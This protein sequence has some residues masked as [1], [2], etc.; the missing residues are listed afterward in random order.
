MPAAASKTEAGEARLSAQAIIDAAPTPLLVLDSNLNVRTVN[1][2]FCRVFQ[3]TREEA[4]GVFV[5]DLANGQW[6]IPELKELLDGILLG[7]AHFTSFEVEHDFALLGLRKMLFS[8]HAIQQG[9][10]WDPLILVSIEDISE[11]KKTEDLLRLHVEV[12]RVASEAEDLRSLTSQCLAAI[13]RYGRWQVA[14]AWFLDESQLLLRCDQDSAYAIQD[15]SAFREVSFATPLAKGVDLPGTV[16]RTSKAVWLSDLTRQMGSPRAATAL[17]AGFKSGF[18]FPI[19]GGDELIGVWEFLSTQPSDQDVNF[20]EAMEGL[21]KHLALVYQSRRTEQSLKTLTGR[22]ITLQ[23]DERRRIA[24]E[25][26]DSTAQSL[27]ALSMNMILISNEAS[28]LSPRAAKLLADSGALLD[29]IGGE[30]RDVAR[31]LHPPML[32]EVGLS[33]ALQW[34]VQCSGL[35]VEVNV[36][37][38]LDRLPREIETALFRIVQEGLSNVRRHAGTDNAKV[39]LIRSRGKIELIISDD[40]KGASTAA[41]QGVATSVMSSGLGVESMRQRVRQLGG[42]FDIMPAEPGTTIKVVLPIPT[43]QK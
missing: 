33:S 38:D 30:V 8:G 32:D 43:E 26:H 16:W 5:Y 3:A 40:G 13:C 2:E 25:L 6:N 7:A 29:Q 35:Q 15:L 1:R 4:S 22:L 12:T 21:G 37:A 14:Q 23:D 36:P 28:A 18:A 20:L 41:R 39:Q 24:R 17:A 42:Q 27:A 19:A 9:E 31:L 34:L 11:R 10:G